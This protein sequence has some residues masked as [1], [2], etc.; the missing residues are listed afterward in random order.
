MADQVFNIKGG[1]FDSINGDRKYSADQMNKPY[2]R[3]ITE[4]VFA[5]QQGTP[6]TDF[7]VV[8]ANNGM[9][10]VCKAGD[11][12]LGGRWI[13]SS[14]DIAISV[15]A[16]TAIVPR[17]DSIILQ[18]DKSQSGRKVN[19]VYREGT[20][21]SN[22]M[23]PAL[24]NTTSMVEI[25]VANIYVAAGANYIGQDAIT[26]L[27]GSSECPWI[28]SLIKQVD[29]STL[30]AQW[31]AAYSNYYNESTADFNEYTAIQRQAWEDFLE[32]LTEDLSVA[33]NIIMYESHY[34]SAGEVTEIPINIPSYDKTT[35]I[36]QVYVNRLR[37]TPDVDYTINSD[38]T[39]IT[40]TNSIVAGQSV[41][42]LCLQSVIAA[43]IQ[44]TISLI[45]TLNDRI[46]TLTADSGWVNFTLE[47]NAQAYS[48]TLTP[49][50]RKYG[51]QVYLRGCLKNITAVGTV[52]ATL[53]VGYR[54]AMTRYYTISTGS[55]T[56]TIEIG[57]NGQLKVANVIGT[58]TAASLI[59][60]DTNF[61]VD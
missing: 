17:R 27:R 49:G 42:F 44:S 46:S 39:K 20:A 47:N 6:S 13:E 23:P 3:I 22:P 50:L 34:T 30:F 57:I 61:I 54:P 18:V 26:D 8:S 5:T 35:D 10:I 7:Q 45:Q 58:L 41:N 11:G 55:I 19:V 2:K 14:S 51:N 36:L 12:L 32:N 48:D 29:T 21:N 1:F 15:P 16:N 52:F 59:P 33:T 24:V 37:A 40:L 28:T 31:Q 38:G 53:P 60:I 56:V 25:R 9:N 4:G 43:D